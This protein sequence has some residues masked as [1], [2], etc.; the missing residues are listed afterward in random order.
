MTDMNKQIEAEILAAN[1]VLS[2]PGFAKSVKRWN[3]LYDI[4]E[5]RGLSGQDAADFIAYF[6]TN[7]KEGRLS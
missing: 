2:A 5:Q 3:T 4:A 7:G 1:P 6:M